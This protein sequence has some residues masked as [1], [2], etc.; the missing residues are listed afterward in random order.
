M[1]K[2]LQIEESYIEALSSHVAETEIEA[3]T[4]FNKKQLT[5]VCDATEKEIGSFVSLEYISTLNRKS[6]FLTLWKSTYSKSNDE[7]LWQITFDAA[8]NKIKLMHVNWEIAW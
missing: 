5:K 8:S 7:V 6:S 2:H 1:L 3:D 4:W